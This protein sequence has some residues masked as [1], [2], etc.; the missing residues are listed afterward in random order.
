[1]FQELNRYS[2]DG[3]KKG[4]HAR[5]Y[6]SHLFFPV[7]PMLYSIVEL[8]NRRAKRSKASQ[9]YNTT[10]TTVRRRKTTV[11]APQGL[12]GYPN[13]NG[14]RNGSNSNG[15]VSSSGNDTATKGCSSNEGYSNGY[16][17]GNHSN[18]N[19]ATSPN[20]KILRTNGVALDIVEEDHHDD[21]SVENKNRSISFDGG[22][23]DKT[24]IPYQGVENK[25]YEQ[26]QRST[27]KS[28]LVD[29]VDI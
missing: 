7:N 10:T 24:S 20:G 18:G 19:G 2:I 14:H 6:L 13:I 26:D 23:V 12:E 9:S 16:S 11:T 29:T 5:Q 27:Q 28:E 21:K 8:L 22:V 1:M 25:G 3:G 17:N 15:G 4:S